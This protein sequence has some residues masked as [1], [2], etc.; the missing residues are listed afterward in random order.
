MNLTDI[1]T[2]DPVILKPTLAIAI[3]MTISEN[4]VNILRKIL[5]HLSHK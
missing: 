4:N 5:I 3:L 2:T 1:V